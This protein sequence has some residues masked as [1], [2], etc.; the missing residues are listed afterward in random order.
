MDMIAGLLHLDMLYSWLLQL[1]VP[2]DGLNA[3]REQ[4]VVRGG[5]ERGIYSSCLRKR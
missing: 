4:V 1:L 2:K 5:S 3:E